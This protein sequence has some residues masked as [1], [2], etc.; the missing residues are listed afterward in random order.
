MVLS[1]ENIEDLAHSVLSDFQGVSDKPL[2]IDIDC[3]ATDYLNLSIQYAALSK[4]QSILGITVYA[5]CDI[6]TIEGT[7]HVTPNTVLLD[8]S[9]RPVPLMEKSQNN[10]RRFTLTHECAHQIL[11]RYESAII[12]EYIKKSYSHRQSFTPR[13]LKTQE[14]WNEWQADTLGAALLMPTN[15][16]YQVWFLFCTGEKLQRYNGWFPPAERNQL[17][18]MSQFLGV[19]QSALLIRLKQLNLIADK[20]GSAYCDPLDVIAS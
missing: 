13:L 20:P 8:N 12:Q 10:R 18:N 1:R 11:Y 4:D 15:L 6:Q 14:D 19:S 7:L 5:A 2:A 9:L 17:N 16:L 3:L